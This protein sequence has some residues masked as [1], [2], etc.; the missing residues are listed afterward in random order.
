MLAITLASFVQP[1]AAQA[2]PPL[3]SVVSGVVSLSGGGTVPDGTQ[4]VGRIDE[5]ESP[6]VTVR[7]GAFENL[8]IA[9]Q[10][11]SLVGRTAS[12]HLE[13]VDVSSGD[14]IDSVTAAE[15][16]IYQPARITGGFTLTFP[17]LPMP[18][19]TPTPVPP[20]PTPTPTPSP[21]PTVTP[22]PTTAQPAIFSGLI[23]VVDGVVPDSARLTARVGAYES[24][25]ALIIGDEFKNLVVDPGDPGLVGQDIEFL[26]DGILSSTVV[27]FASGDSNRNLDLVF[28]GLPTPTPTPTLTP[29]PTATP[30]PSP[31]PTPTA[32]ATPTPTATAVPPTPTPTPTPTATAVPP[33]PTPSPPPPTPTTV[34][35]PTATPDPSGFFGTCSAPSG[36][37]PVRAGV[38]NGL[39]LLGPLGLIWVYRRRR[40]AGE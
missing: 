13:L 12:F 29:A 32:T 2:P 39:L 4:L 27:K 20:T 21:T 37:A 3:P 22:T 15:G 17:R 38:V 1:V 8:V 14:L 26:L 23:I 31:T 24:D 16:I 28:R 34:V 33:T 7:D 18:P 40:S 25:L 36:D 11:S 35:E 19:A 6:A 5:Y 30:T 10:D 9:P